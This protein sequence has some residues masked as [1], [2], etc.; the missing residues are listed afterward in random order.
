MRKKIQSILGMMLVMALPLMLTGCEELSEIDNPV[1]VEDASVG[2]EEEETKEETKEE[3]EEE[4]EEKVN[5]TSV[6]LDQTTL[7]KTLGDEA[8]TLTATVN[9]SNAT[10]KTVTWK[11][12][13]E[14]VATV[15]NGVVTFV[16]TG[17]A[18]ITATATNGTEETTDDKT[19]TCTVTVKVKG[20]ASATMDEVWIEMTM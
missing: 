1:V 7:E 5:V 6:T 19:A 4:T 13:N 18:T 20:D 15:A 17:E 11:S 2:E 10:D 8:V 3:K 12:S 16:A 9:P 14:S